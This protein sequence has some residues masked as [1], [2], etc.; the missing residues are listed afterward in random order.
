MRH[1]LQRT[2]SLRCP[3][4]L[5]VAL[6]TKSK[7][8]GLTYGVPHSLA[9]ACLLDPLAATGLMTPDAGQFSLHFG[10]KPSIYIPFADM[11][12][13]TQPFIYSYAIPTM[14]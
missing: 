5:S 3:A 9:P 14:H 8:L 1:D 7:L 12:L 10:P 6:R 2:Q 13:L 11:Y 4:L